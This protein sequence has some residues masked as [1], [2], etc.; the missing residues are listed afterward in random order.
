MCQCDP[1]PLYCC[2]QDFLSLIS[3]SLIMFWSS[4]DPAS[5]WMRQKQMLTPR[6]WTEVGDPYGWIRGRIEE[7]E[8]GSD[9]IGRPAVPTNPDPREFPET[10]PP[11]RS[12]HRLPRGP[13]HTEVCLVRPQWEKMDFILKSLEAPGKGGGPVRR[14]TPSQRQAGGGMGTVGGGSGG[15]T[16]M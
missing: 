3:P 8:R 4:L 16:G 1:W 5:S 7:A 2:F 6:H 13:W 10:E 11:T 14:K 15:T 12:I 9:P